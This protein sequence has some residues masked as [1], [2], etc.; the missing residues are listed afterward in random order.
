[1]CR[2][3][4]EAIRNGNKQVIKDC[5]R[6]CTVEEG[7]DWLPSSPEELCGK[8]FHT[9]Y[10]GTKAASSPETRSRAKDLSGRIGAYHTDMNID[11]L[12]KALTDLFTFVTN[13]VPK[14]KTQGGTGAENLALQNIQARLRMVI[15]YLFAQLLPT[16][17]KRPGGGGLLVLGSANVDGELSLLAVQPQ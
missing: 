6:L 7:S 11:T 16:V 3:V 5:R 4:L 15:I 2:L 9:A 14:F 1:M 10:M 13:F 17:R 8:I 12:V